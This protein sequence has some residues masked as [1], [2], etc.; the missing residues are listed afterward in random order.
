VGVGVGVGGCEWVS[1][2]CDWW[3]RHSPSL[4]V[5]PSSLQPQYNRLP[6]LMH[7]KM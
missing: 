3:F 4:T 5:G 1:C 7:G 6:L 2:H